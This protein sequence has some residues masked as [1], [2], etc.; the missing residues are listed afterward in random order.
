MSPELIISL[1]SIG[2]NFLIGGLTIMAN[3]RISKIS[4]LESIKK[5]DKNI[6]NF[7]LQF[8]DEHWLHNLIETGDF[9]LYNIKSKKRICA[10]WIKYSRKNPPVLLIPHIDYNELKAPGPDQL[11]IGG[12]MTEMVMPDDL[13]NAED[14]F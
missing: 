11:N 10:W 6:T 1:I 3:I 7:E 8:K 5:Y 13:P 12:R 9:D 14:L 4:H 2:L